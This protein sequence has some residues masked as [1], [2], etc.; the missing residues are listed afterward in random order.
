M[1]WLLIGYM[2]L[3][4]HRPFELYPALGDLHVERVYILGVLAYWLIYPKKRWLPNPQ[5][6]AYAAFACAVVACWLASPWADHGQIVVENWLKIVVFYVLL[7]TC[8][9]DEKALRRLVAGFLA[10]MAIYMLH[11]LKEYVG[12]RYTFRMGIAR[13]LGVDTS[14]GDPNSFGA[15]IVFALPFVRAFWLWSKSSL[16]RVSLLGYLGL[17]AGC[18]ALTGSR[19]SLLGLCLWMTIV[20][21]QSRQRWLGLAAAAILAPMAFLA[22]P[23]SLQNR[24]ETMINPEVGPESARVSGD[25]RIDG[26]LKG[27]ELIA[28]YP[29]TGVGPGSWRPA[30]GSKLESHNLI[31]QLCGEMGMLGVITFVAILGCFAVNLRWMR[32]AARRDPAGP[33]EFE[34]RVSGAVAMAIFLLLV[35]GLFGHNLFRHNWLWFGGFLIIGRY[36]VQKR[37]RVNAMVPTSMRIWGSFTRDCRPMH[38]PYTSPR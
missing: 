19:S 31:G 1:H 24:F 22:L 3:F 26:F 28:A 13:M 10:V 18:I 17:S 38:V 15:S 34:H 4:I 33:L 21:L 7:V 2:F 11:S 8:A 20:I 32:R 37:L 14:M 36:V 27:M 6:L 5:H 35:M 29:A 9:S 25:G 30:T 16:V 23:P 12:G